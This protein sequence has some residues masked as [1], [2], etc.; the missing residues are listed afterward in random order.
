MSMRAACCLLPPHRRC[1]I[2]MSLQTTASSSQEENAHRAATGR[3][4]VGSAESDI[5]S[6]VGCHNQNCTRCATPIFVRTS[7]DRHGAM[8]CNKQNFVKRDSNFPDSY[9]FCVADG[10]TRFR[11]DVI[12]QH[13]LPGRRPPH[14]GPNFQ[15][16]ASESQH[17]IQPR[18][19]K[20]S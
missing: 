13:R 11:Y 4:G 15:V 2:S 20:P 5:G 9:D 17:G 18:H 16:S 7:H 3:V 10:A 1:T 12:C 19:P 8:S 6:S 14:G